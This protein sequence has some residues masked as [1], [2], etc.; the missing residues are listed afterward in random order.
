MSFLVLFVKLSGHRGHKAYSCDL[1]ETEIPGK[2]YKK[3]VMEEI[4]YEVMNIKQPGKI[5]YRYTDGWYEVS[6]HGEIIVQ[7]HP[8]QLT[9]PVIRETKKSYFIEDWGIRRVPKTG[10]NIY[11]WNTEKK[12]LFNYLKRKEIHKQILERNV[13]R[14]EANRKWAE[15]ELSKIEKHETENPVS[16]LL[17]F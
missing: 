10:K 6:L 8:M 9:F 12:A 1:E 7:A 14:A 4:M 13:K 15:E 3:D 16:T 2:H 5:L 17:N 11:A